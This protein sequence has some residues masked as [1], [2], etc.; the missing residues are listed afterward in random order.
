MTK[1]NLKQLR[2]D[3]KYCTKNLKFGEETLNKGTTDL[4]IESTTDLPIEST[5]DLP[6]ESTTDLPIGKNQNFNNFKNKYL[7]KKNA[8]LAGGLLATGLIIKNKKKVK[9]N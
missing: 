4:P 6:I 5:T 9:L 7:T 8:L 2:K 3:L 1:L